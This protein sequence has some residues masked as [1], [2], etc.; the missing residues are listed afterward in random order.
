MAK[1]ATAVAWLCCAWMSGCG[2]VG[3][4]LTDETRETVENLVEAGF[5]TEDIQVVDGVVQVGG[6]A[7][8]SLQASREMLDTGGST[9]E[10]YRTTNLVSSAV[11]KVTVQLPSPV[12]STIAAGLAEAVANY[13]AL[14]LRLTFYTANPCLADP[15]ACPPGSHATINVVVNSTL[16]SGP[17][18]ASGYPSGGLPYPTIW[19]G[20]GLSTYPLDVIEHVLTH[21]LGHTIGFRHTDF[22]NTAISC[23]GTPVREGANPGGAIL[24][25]GTPSSATPGGSIMNTCVPLST[26]GEFTSTDIAALNFM[27]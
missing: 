2:G 25:P 14:G 24:I 1:K 10:H 27:Y 9:A 22:F 4:V 12:A 5:R 18:G 16:P 6:D 23:G 19:I 21:E 7:V 3:P 17:S 8:V 26:N 20:T 11:R 13:N 15:S